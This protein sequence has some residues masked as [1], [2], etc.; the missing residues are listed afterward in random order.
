M[1]SNIP[2]DGTLWIK[3]RNRFASNSL[4]LVATSRNVPAVPCGNSGNFNGLFCCSVE[5]NTSCCNSTF[6]NVFGKPFAPVTSAAT[7]VNDTSNTN[8]SAIITANATSTGHSSS[9]ATKIG[10]GVGVPLGL[11]LLLSLIFAVW[12]ERRR[13]RDMERIIKETAW[14]GGQWDRQKPPADGVNNVRYEVDSGEREIQELG[15]RTP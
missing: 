9:D 3:F 8:T 2:D 7:A 5:Q 4:A 6:G 14:S 15:D 13:R 12:T 1:A 10:V 11:L